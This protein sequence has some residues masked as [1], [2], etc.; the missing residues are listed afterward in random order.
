MLGNWVDNKHHNTVKFL[1]SIVPNSSVNLPK[2]YNRRT[3][4]KAVI[5]QSC[6]PKISYFLGFYVLPLT[7]IKTAIKINYNYEKLNLYKLVDIN[8][9]LIKNRLL[10]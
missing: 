4:N 9:F 5:L 8:L 6:I 7:L 1:V 10:T 2:V 3:S